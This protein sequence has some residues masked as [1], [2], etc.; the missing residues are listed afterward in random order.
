MPSTPKHI[1]MYEA[2]G[3][4]PPLYAHVGLLQNN[5]RQKYSKRKG[6]ED[7]DMRSLAMNG[8]FPE[9]LTNY[10]ALHGWSHDL[11]DDF[12]RMNDLVKNVWFSCSK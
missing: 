2:L 12:L 6:D 9:A 11:G 10:V 3:W 5:E 7:L 8:A 1:V 4:E